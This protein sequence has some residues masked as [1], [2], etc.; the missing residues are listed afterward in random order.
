MESKIWWYALNNEQKG[1]ISMSEIKLL[2][3]L[4]VLTNET[5]VWKQ[6]FKN[7]IKFSE[8]EESTLKQT[9]PSQTISYND[10]PHLSSSNIDLNSFS[11]DS[12]YRE[13]FGKIISSNEFY[14]GKWNWWAFLF[15][16]IWCFSKG[17]WALASILLLPTLF[18]Y[19]SDQTKTI[20][21]LYILIWSIVI[22]NRGTWF[23]YNLKIKGKQI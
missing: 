2:R 14:K 17:L 15:G 6:D 11:I 16:T 21:F 18:L 7:W 4:N 8:I 5:L 3:E 9:V 23:Y 22:G 12:Y 1:P 13:E 10:Q 20:G 19:S